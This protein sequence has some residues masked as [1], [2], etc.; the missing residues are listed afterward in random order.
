MTKGGSLAF[1][2][3]VISNPDFAV[4][5]QLSPVVHDPD[6]ELS[7]NA[8]C[9]VVSADTNNSRWHVCYDS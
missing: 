5:D 7:Q 8:V 1:A 2:F 3:A 6:A 9:C 4:I